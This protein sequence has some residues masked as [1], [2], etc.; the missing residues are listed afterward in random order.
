MKKRHNV[1]QQKHIL[2]FLVFV[3]NNIAPHHFPFLLPIF[4]SLSTFLSFS[5]KLMKVFK[6]WGRSE[7][8]AQLLLSVTLTASLSHWQASGT[9]FFVQ[10]LHKNEYQSIRKDS[11]LDRGPYLPQCLSLNCNHSHSHSHRSKQQCAH[12]IH[13]LQVSVHL[14]LCMV[15]S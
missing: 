4:S 8:S 14:S 7:V 13:L 6:I 12:R 15:C 11:Q 9:D 10:I 1:M 2:M 5:D 3:W